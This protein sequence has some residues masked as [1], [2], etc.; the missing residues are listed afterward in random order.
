MNNK[1][2][3]L[4]KTLPELEKIVS[5]NGFPKFVSKQIA[6]WLYKKRVSDI[7]MMTN[8]GKAK[9]D[10]L[11]EKYIV[12][13]I[14]YSSLL[15]STDGTKKYLFKTISSTNIETA[16][17]P[18][19]ERATLCV[20]SQ[21]GC[22]MGCEFCMTARGGYNGNLS[23]GEIINQIYRIDDTEKLTNIVYMGMG[24][25]LDNKA[26]VFKSLEILTSDW[27]FGWSPTRITLSSIGVIPSL[28]QF[29]DEFKV[30][31]AI[32]LHNPI[33]EERKKIMP[34]ENKYP[35]GRVIELLKEYDFSHQRRVSFE[36]IMFDGLN[37]TK[38]HLNKL[39]DLLKGLDCRINLIRF[40]KIPDSRLAPSPESRI[41][42]FRDALTSRGIMTTIRA[43]RGEDIYAACGMLSNKENI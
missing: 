24:E 12:G 5:E 16:Y 3:L 6:D 17:I 31:L 32:S 33:S 38:I 39:I 35:I 42:Q 41:L 4:G 18:D 26:E 7:S 36:Y 8:L 2:W 9:I 13:A 23:A 25:P 37:D 10:K 19:R 14:P 1:E 15:T 29:L 21:I 22:R 27:G 30:H 11:S 28:K 43:S 40:H 34:V 20:S